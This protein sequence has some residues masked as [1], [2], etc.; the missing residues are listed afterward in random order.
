MGY[1]S[2]VCIGLTDPATRLLATILEHLPKDHE[3]HR[4]IED[5]ASSIKL[6][7]RSHKNTKMDCGTK[8]YWDS[9][10]WYEGYE[11]VDFI[12]EFLSMIPPE[13]Y[14]LVRLGEEVDDNYESGEYFDSDIYISRS[15][16]W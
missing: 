11:C 4:L 10:K 14:R 2:E 3:T 15:I 7:D 16:S 13:D 8:L 6:R 1:R 12:E 5:T 9:V